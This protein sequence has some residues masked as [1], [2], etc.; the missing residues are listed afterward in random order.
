MNNEIKRQN[1]FK[2][3]DAV[4]SSITNSPSRYKSSD[5]TN[6]DEMLLSIK[7]LNRN[8]LI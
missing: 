2:N 6:K 8:S 1:S 4:K 5:N 3:F 7:A